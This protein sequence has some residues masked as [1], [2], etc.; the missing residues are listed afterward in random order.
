MRNSA[1]RC[2]TAKRGRPPA[3]RAGLP[4]CLLIGMLAPA[5]IAFAQAPQSQSGIAAAQTAPSQPAAPSRSASP[6]PATV[7][8]A[9]LF[10]AQPAPT[11]PRLGGGFI[12][13]FGRWWDGAQGKLDDLIKQ[14]NNP[15]TATRDALS[16][17]AQETQKAANA[18]IR[19]PGLRVIEVHQRCSIAPNGAPDCR[20]AA[21]N[22]CRAKGFSDGHPVNVQSSENCPPAVW[23]SGR[24]PVP[25]E[26]PAETVV[27]MVACQ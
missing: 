10:P 24:E 11:Q 7:P 26:C 13:A 1:D 5:A 4:V 20:I 9:G 23:M 2:I 14:Q 27:L 25:G 21:T 6:A 8:P 19:L 22:A 15:A 3:N 18:L 16:N 17:A 12:Y